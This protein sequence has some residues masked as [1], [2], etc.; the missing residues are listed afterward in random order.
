[1]KTGLVLEGGALRTIFSSG[2][3][4]AFLD[5]DLMP[6]CVVG[7]SAGIAYGVSYVSRQKWRN[8]HILSSYARDPRYMGWRNLADGH[9]RSYFGLK[10]AYEDIPNS[11]IPFDYDT[12][13]A[14]PGEVEAVVTNLNTGRADYLPVPRRDGHFL[15][16]Q[17]TCAMPLLFPIFHIDGQPYLDG[18][19]A[20]PIPWR[21]ALELG[22]DRVVVILTRERSFVR[23]N[24]KIQRL[25]DRRYRAYPNFL[26]VMHSRTE[27]YNACRQ[28]LFELERQGRV[29]LLAPGDTRGFSRIERDQS[30]ILALW[31]DGYFQGRDAAAAVRAFWNGEPSGQL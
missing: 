24:E 9:N 23:H 26:S 2:V 25:V 31:Q 5:A 12:F 28:E 30:K 27:R 13:S 29:L 3:C 7:V 6:D 8:L 16:L 4:D 1:M 17:A 22:C 21:R 18:G 10:L 15:L 14:F 19:C 20:D 11:L